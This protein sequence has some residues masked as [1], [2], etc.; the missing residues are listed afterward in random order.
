[1]KYAVLLFFAFVWSGSDQKSFQEGQVA[2][3]IEMTN[4]KGEVVKLSSLRG[5]MVFI[6]FWASW[7]KPC[8]KENPEIVR[9]YQT[10]KDESFDN[11]EGFAVFS[12]SLDKKQEAW[13]KAIVKDSL[14]WDTHV[15]DL[16]GWKSDA[17]VAYGISSIPMSYL[18]DGDGVIVAVNPRGD[19]LEKELKKNRKSDSWFKSLFDK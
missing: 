10:Y 5:Q 7:C 12:V 8:R 16:K 9:V 3:D 4:L 11:G 18:I 2:P 19:K 14:I 15:S 13:Q 17:A 1:M 6:D